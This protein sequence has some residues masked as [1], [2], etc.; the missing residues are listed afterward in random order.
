MRDSLCISIMARLVGHS[1]STKESTWRAVITV[2]SQ[3]FATRLGL[4]KTKVILQ[5]QPSLTGKR[6]REIVTVRTFLVTF[7]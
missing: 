7:I 3:S 1:M 5:Y 6:K 2:T 4:V